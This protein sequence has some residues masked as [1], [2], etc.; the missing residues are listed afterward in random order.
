MIRVSWFF[1]W[2]LLVGSWNAQAQPAARPRAVVGIMVDQMRME[3]LSRFESKLGEHGF[4]RLMREG[5]TL[6]NAHYNYMPTVTGPG[7]ASVY[8]GT[9]PAVHGIIGNEFFDKVSKKMVNCVEDP[10]HK[11]IGSEG[12]N[13]DV[14]PWRLL[15]T[16]ITDELKLFTQ[17]RAKVISMSI[18]D[19]GAVLPGG[20]MADAAYWYDSKTGRFITS[21]YYMNQLPT[22]VD[23]FNKQNKADAYLNQP[24]TTTFPPD[25]YVE[26]GPDASPYERK[27]SGKPVSAFPY[28]LKEM[29]AKNGNFDL[30]VYT[31]FSNDYLTEFATK[32]ITEEKLGADEITDFLCLSYSTP[33]ILG[34]AVGPNAVEIE[35]M[36]IKLDKNIEQ[37]LTTLD[38]TVGVGNYTVFLTA[39]HAVADVP[40]YLKDQRIPA[41]TLNAENLKVRLADFLAA[42]YPGKKL[43][44]NISNEQIFLNHQA[45]SDEPRKAGVDLLIVKELI[46][47]FLM[48]TEGVHTYFTESQLR[49]S[50]FAEGGIKGSVVRGFHHKRS[51][52]LAVVLE[53]GWFASG[54]VQGTTHGAPW[55]YD[56]HVPILWFGKGIPSGSSVR[57]YAITDIA[58]T[59]SMLLGIKLPNGC[60]GQPIEE[61]FQK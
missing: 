17:K 38:K 9:T 20:H 26:S 51:G 16:T 59:L 4:K 13:G 35:D 18:K 10:A 55:T 23:Q 53:P 21:T 3:Y 15:S 47:Q 44:E 48:D 27:F 14:S 2:G 11:P 42:H 45:F 22:W 54:W 25:Q 50:D 58:P 39:D 24:W 52:D 41:G 29:R 31:P 19:R 8:T 46:G 40:Q 5:F 37:L 6:R 28:N 7:H 32:A 43:I 57:Y 60:S 34:H 36:Y 49:Q 61:L 1:L 56:T 30:L 33:D 12:G